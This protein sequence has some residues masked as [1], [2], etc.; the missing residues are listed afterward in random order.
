M[1][2][3]ASLGLHLGGG[4][5]RRSGVSRGSISSRSSR[6]SRGSRGGGGCGLRGIPRVVHCSSTSN[7]QHND[8]ANSKHGPVVGLAGRGGGGGGHGL[9]AGARHSLGVDLGARHRSLHLGGILRLLDG[10]GTDG[11]RALSGAH[12]AG[13]HNVG[14]DSNSRGS[15]GRLRDINLG[16]QCRFACALL[17]HLLEL[18]LIGKALVRG[19]GRSGKQQTSAHDARHAHCHGP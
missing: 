2:V 14:L 4:G 1:R 8:S 9:D 16:R 6:S 5:G 3:A 10:L 15:C 7:G 19:Q 18:L 17:D 12:L 13:H 11:L